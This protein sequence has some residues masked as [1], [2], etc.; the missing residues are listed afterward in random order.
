MARRANEKHLPYY[1]LLETLGS[2]VD[3]PV[4]AQAAEAIR[5]RIE[6]LL[7]ESVTDRAVAAQLAA[8]W[9]FCASHTE[10]L[11][12]TGDAL[13]VGLL[14][15]SVLARWLERLEQWTPTRQANPFAA[16]Q[17]PPASAPCPLCAAEHEREDRSAETI[18]AWIADEEFLDAF[19]EAAPLCPSHFVLVLGKCRA[20]GERQGLVVI[21]Q[22]KVRALLGELEELIASYDYR[23]GH[24]LSERQKDSWHRAARLVAR[25]PRPGPAPRT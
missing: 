22:E 6:A 9:G 11:I 7:Y 25:T 19:R 5:A 2:A 24:D 15:R 23:S 18:A 16:R 1:E 4:C 21:E 17:A 14:H 20:N 8:S 12:A 3:C 10:Q 13:G